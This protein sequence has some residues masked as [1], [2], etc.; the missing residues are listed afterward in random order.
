MRDALTILHASDLQCGRPYLPHAAEA[1]IRFARSLAPDVVVISGDLTQRAKAREFRTAADL[2]RRLPSVPTIVTP[3]N[4]DV[5]VYRVWER[6]LAP[7]RSWRAGVSPDLD[8]VTRVDGATFVALN[9]TAPWRAVVGGRIDAWQIDYAREAFA[10]SESGEVRA[11]VV[12]HHFVPTPDGTGGS[13]LPGAA[14]LVR[15]FE[16]MQVDFVLGGHV[17]RTHVRT[18]RDLV[19]GTGEGVPL[20]ACGTTTSRR[21][22]GPE[23]GANSFNVVR[24]LPKALEIQPHVM[25][26][27]ADGF[28]PMDPIVLPRGR[29]AELARGARDP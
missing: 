19:D 14:H 25:S 10:T 11:L 8:T 2:L 4:H 27:G 1:L 29:A 7:Y 24:V 12:H 18:S 22:R 16:S 20:I 9:S 3:G 5:P 13:P 15:S 26:D 6:A 23:Q 28:V 21:G 17:H